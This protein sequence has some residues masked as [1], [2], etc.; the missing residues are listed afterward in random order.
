MKYLS[1][2]VA[3][4]LLVGFTESISQVYPPTLEVPVTFYDFHT[5]S[6]NPEFE[7]TPN[8]AARQLNMVAPTLD[9]VSKP[10]LGNTPYFN[11]RIDRWFRSWQPGD[12]IIYN[13]YN[14]GDA[15]AN[16]YVRYSSLPTGLTNVGHD[17]AFI[18]KTIDSVLIF[19]YVPNSPGTYEFESS[20]FFPLDGK[21]YGHEGALPDHNYGFTMELHWEFTMKDSLEFHFRGDDDVWVFIGGQRVMDI[22]G[23]H[24]PEADVLYLDQY[25]ANGTFTRGQRYTLDFFYAE[26]HVTGSNI[27]ISTN[28]ISAEPSEIH[29]YAY[30]SDTVCAGEQLMAVAV[31]IDND[32]NPLPVMSDSTLWRIIPNGANTDAHLSTNNPTNP[33]MGDTIYFNP[34]EAYALEG[35]EGRLQTSSGTIY[36]TIW[37]YVKACNPDHVTI[38]GNP[39]PFSTTDQ[40]RNDQPLSVITISESATSGNGYAIVRDEFGNFITASNNTS[41]TITGGAQYI[42]RV[43]VGNASQGEGIVYKESGLTEEGNGE[44]TATCNMYSFPITPDNVAVRILQIS[45]DSLQISILDGSVYRR[46]TSLITTTDN[47]TL[48]IVRGKRSDNGNWEVVE[49]NW[50]MTGLTSSTTAPQP[51]QSWNFTPIDTAHGTITVANAL[52]TTLKTS[53]PVIVGT[54]APNSLEIFPNATGTQYADPPTVYVDSAGIEFPLYAKV[55]DSRGVWLRQYDS[56]TAPI[57]WR[58]IELSGNTNTPTGTYTRTTGNRTGFTPTRARNVVDLV[59]TFSSGGRTFYDTVR[60]RVVPGRPDHITIQE[61]TTANGRDLTRLDMQSNETEAY[62]YAILRDRFDNFIDFVQGALWWSKDTTI[63]QAEPT[64]TGTFIGEGV[65]TRRSDSVSQTHVFTSTDDGSLKDSILIALTNITYDSLRIY[66]LDGGKRIVDTVRIRID[67]TLT[68]YVEGRRSDG[69]GWDNITATWDKSASLITI[70]DPP[71]RSD[72]WPVTPDSVG[73]GRITVSRTG[74]VSDSVVAIFL[75]GLPGEVRLYR[76]TGTPSAAGPYRR[77]PQIDTLTAGVSAPFVAKIF[78]RNNIW[79]SDYENAARNNLFSWTMTLVSGF[80]PPDTLSARTGY[81]VA[82]LP[83]SAYNTYNVT[84][85]FT[86]GSQVYTASALVYVKPGPVDHL[87]IEGSPNP[88]GTALQNDNPL[89]T[90]EFGNRDTVKTAFAVLRDRFGNFIS[91]SQ[92]TNWSSVNISIVTAIEGLAIAGE[93][94]ITRVGT[95]GSTKVVAVNRN[96]TSLFDTVDVVLSQFSYDSLRIVVDDS[97]HIQ[98]LEMRSDQDTVLQVIGKRSFDGVWVPVTGDWAYT[99]NTESQSAQSLTAW[100]FVPTDTGSGIIVVSRGSA[101]PDTVWV[102]I[103]PG[104]PDKLVLYEREGEVPD[105]SNPPYP[106]P[107]TALTAVAGT[108]FPLVAKILD[109]NGVWLP[110]YEQNP[111]LSRQIRWEIIEIPPTDSSGFLDD[112]TG[113]KRSFT[114]VRAYQSVYVVAWLYVDANHT[115][116]DTVKLE[117]VPGEAAQLVI[118][119]SSVYDPIR[120]NSIDTAVIPSSTTTTRVYAI[121]RDSIG[122]YV[123]YSE[124]TT[125]GVVDDDI[126]VT[127]RNGN[128]TVGEGVISRNVQE[129]TVKVFAIDDETGFR[130]STVVRLLAFFYTQLRIV[131]GTDTAADSLTMTTNDDTTL[132]VQGLRSDSAIWVDVE[133]HWE[134]SGNLTIVPGAPGWSHSWPFSP[135]DTGRGWIRVTMDDD[136]QTLPDTLWVTFLPGPPTKVTIKIITPEDKRIAGEPIEVVLEITNENGLVP[137]EYCFDK[138]DGIMYTDTLGDGGRPRP[139]VV[140]GEDTVYL[141]EKG[142]RQCFEGG[143]DTITTTLFYVPDEPADS[144]HRITVQLGELTARTTPFIL[145]PGELDKLVLEYGNGDP[146]GDTISM[147]YPSGHVTMF[148]IGYDKYGNRI[149]PIKSDWSADSTLHKIDQATRTERIVY[150]ASNVEDNEA[151]TITAVPSDTAYDH[152]SAQVFVKITGPLIK[153]VE[154]KTRDV[155]GNGYLD[156]ITLTFSRP[157]TFP[158]DYDFDELR[159]SYGLTEFEIDSIV[160]IGERSDSVW[161]IRLKENTSEGPQTDWTPYV[162]IDRNMEMTV[163]SLTE[164]LSIDGAGPVVWKVE[165]RIT[166]VLDRTADEVRIIFSEDVQRAT[167][168]GQSLSN[169]DSLIMII[170]VWEAIP[171][172]DST[173]TYVLV[174]SML[175]GIDNIQSTGDDELTFLVLNGED[176]ASRHRISI[177]ILTADGDT[178]AYITDRADSPNL[179]EFTNQLVPIDIIGAPPVI[180][181][182]PNPS[183]PTASHVKPGTIK[184]EHTVDAKRWAYEEG[185]GVLIRITLSLPNI[186]TLRQQN[187]TLSED[188]LLSIIKNIKLPAFLKIY[189]F[190]GNTVNYAETS[191]LLKK[192][193]SEALSGRYSVYDLDLFWNGFNKGGMPVAPGIY[194]FV[195][196]S[197][198]NHPLYRWEEKFVKTIGIRH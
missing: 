112:T 192:L 141:T 189:D 88:T 143:R 172:G 17:T 122:N 169:S 166:N 177:R 82:M 29:L 66:I 95:L 86:E 67:E 120:A 193:P 19:D 129:D 196:K 137:G 26:R 92:S 48:L 84:V 87:V 195:L 91:A 78:D 24:G 13:Y 47:D 104:L 190:V 12:S 173:Y 105:G 114:P 103:N 79:L 58:I 94:R 194:R 157:V 198:S 107:L 154:A 25:I 16:R 3:C 134:N 77:P 132:Y 109:H 1:I 81:N 161:V 37:I 15:W 163:D 96:N 159:I 4:L 55:F 99:A 130:D 45:Y 181:I 70:G 127:V 150:I 153:L 90:I 41:W 11:R 148:S 59:A 36:D 115:F 98:I 9:S 14:A 142:D 93:G 23:I 63:V 133:A 35:I 7:I 119:G 171:N 187:P 75:P 167:G 2:M 18:N 39:P 83:T 118:E 65:V 147:E 49:G 168:E 180:T 110:E 60:V 100:T 31:V 152:I 22:G 101:V 136:A 51:G 184:L 38:E 174:D 108:P 57:S 64:L 178:S 43:E 106:D 21:G 138:V 124:V 40:L 123:S 131:V 102:N 42:D 160:G 80:N 158:E 139:F 30:P 156:Q 176:I 6:S 113:H 34:T 50:S 135:A 182:A 54:G 146:V 121:V 28:I 183:R 46:I 74:A 179:P 71:E 170:Y 126:A 85:T 62:L 164:L 125:W 188:S 175:Q 8:P 162:S 32:G 191:N 56:L 155:N 33:L 73:T 111:D 68:L 27:Q 144:L 116:L 76:R 61:D 185:G 151:G 186:E 117:I 69:Q 140:L 52:D 5:D 20:S 44:V 197:S 53:I 97:I 145:L 72:N 10:I 149:G 89:S 165:K 128:T